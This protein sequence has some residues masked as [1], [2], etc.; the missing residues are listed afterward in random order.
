[1]SRKNKIKSI[2]ENGNEIEYKTIMDAAKTINSKLDNWKI[3]LFIADAINRNGRA[4][5][6]SWKRI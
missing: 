5:K 3:G 4:F 1:M 2:D 6:L